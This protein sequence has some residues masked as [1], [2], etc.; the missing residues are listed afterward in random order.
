MASSSQ[1]LL[2][3]QNGGLPGN[4]HLIFHTRHAWST[5]HSTSMKQPWE[6][7]LPIVHKDVLEPFSKRLR[8]SGNL[9]PASVLAENCK[10]D[11]LAVKCN[12]FASAGLKLMKKTDEHLWELQITFDRKAAYKKWTTLILDEP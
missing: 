11:E 1:D 12:S 8:L 9:G 5:L 10:S 3:K 4:E 7:T 2:L 6:L